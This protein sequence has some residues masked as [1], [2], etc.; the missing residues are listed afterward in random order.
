MPTS[1]KTKIVAQPFPY[2]KPTASKRG[3]IAYNLL[4]I[5]LNTKVLGLIIRK[6]INNY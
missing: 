1:N 3:K 4:A 5:P 2:H 6:V